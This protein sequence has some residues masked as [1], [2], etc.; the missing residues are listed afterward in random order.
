[1]LVE[2]KGED[3]MHQRS[4]C[5]HRK[6]LMWCDCVIFVKKNYILD[7]PN[8]ADALSRRYREVRNKEFI[9]KPCHTKLKH[10]QFS[11][12]NS[13][14]VEHSENVVVMNSNDTT[15]SMEF[16]MTSPDF[17]QNAKYTNHCICTCCY[18][19]DLPRSQC[20]I[21]KASR[22]NSDNSVISNGLSNHFVAFT[23][24]EFICKKC[25][26]SLLAEKCLL[27]LLMPDVD[28]KI[29]NRKCVFTLKVYQ[30]KVYFLTSQHMETTYWPLKYMRI[31]CNIMIV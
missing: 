9:C 22:Y 7:N 17:T 4:T 2:Q 11:K 27:M 26:K 30:L 13:N 19:P 6:N 8:V 3:C 1:M 18:K 24:K 20:I 31:V 12:V 5:C 25:D 14:D 16:H 29:A 28:Y 23:A 10:S 21:S 15:L